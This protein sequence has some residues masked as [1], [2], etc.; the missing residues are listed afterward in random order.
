MG[1]WTSLDAALGC[2]PVMGRCMLQLTSPLTMTSRTH[3]KPSRTVLRLMAAFTLSLLSTLQAAGPPCGAS[4]LRT[5]LTPLYADWN[6]GCGATVRSPAVQL[7]D[8]SQEGI[9]GHPSI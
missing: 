8:T 9:D 3:I 7:D 1:V 4:S 5:A 2:V 6:A